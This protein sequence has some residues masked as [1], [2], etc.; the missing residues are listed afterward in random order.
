M[1]RMLLVS[2]RSVVIWWT[3]ESSNACFC[4]SS[5]LSWFCFGLNSSKSDYFEVLAFSRS[6]LFLSSY[7]S[8][9]VSYLKLLL[10]LGASATSTTDLK[11]LGSEMLESS[12]PPLFLSAV[13][14]FYLFDAPNDD[15]ASVCAARSLW[16]SELSKL[17]KLLSELFIVLCSN[18]I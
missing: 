7:P 13:P 16:L 8:I 4:G 11:G 9:R 3:L 15:L 10:L 2:F 17:S 14:L 6:C 18:I 5:L 1:L 12:K